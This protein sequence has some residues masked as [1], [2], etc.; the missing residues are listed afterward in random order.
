MGRWSEPGDVALA[1]VIMINSRLSGD[2][3]DLRTDYIRDF[4]RGALINRAQTNGGWQIS[5]QYGCG[6]SCHWL[7]VV[8]YCTG[9]S[10]FRPIIIGYCALRIVVN[11]YVLASEKLLE[12]STTRCLACKSTVLAWHIYSRQNERD[13]PKIEMGGTKK[14]M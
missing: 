14:C 2:C 12:L 3:I 10:L 5:H 6:R 9:V 1:D 13:Y 11:D 4:V 7:R 8:I